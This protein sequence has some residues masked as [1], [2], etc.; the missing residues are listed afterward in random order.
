MFTHKLLAPEVSI[1]KKSVVKTHQ[2]IV[3]GI[4]RFLIKQGERVNQVIEEA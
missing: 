4:V 3:K 2:G 1:V